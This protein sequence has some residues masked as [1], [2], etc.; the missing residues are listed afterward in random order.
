[1]NLLTLSVNDK[2]FGVQFLQQR[3]II[4]NPR[5][6]ANGHPM[7]LQLRDKGDRWRCHSRDCRTEVALRKDTWLEGSKLAYR[8]IVLF[9]YCW[10]REYTKIIFVK[11]ELGIG[12]D[13]TIDFNNYLREVCAADLLARRKNHQGRV[14]PQQWV[15][16]AVKPW[17]ALCMLCLAVALL[18]CCQLFKIPYDQALPSCQPYGELTVVF[19]H[20]KVW[21]FN[22]LQLTTV[23]SL[24][25]PKQGHTLV[26]RSW[27]SA[28][29]RNKRQR[30]ASIHT[31]VNGCG[32]KD[33]KT[34]TCLITF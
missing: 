11:E 8:D 22:T 2:A 32:D 10:S 28:K 31:Y 16:G 13:A 1:M 30:N 18:P 33:T 29:E 19:Q 23:F 24:W 9:I 4:H 34:L 15:F 7:T 14:L 25:I 6:C 26:E 27:K 17:K 20:C 3:G 12:K 5:I 21:V